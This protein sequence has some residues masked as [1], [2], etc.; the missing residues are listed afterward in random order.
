MSFK[1]SSDF[2]IVGLYFATNFGAPCDPYLIS[3]AVS[4]RR[5]G[6]KCD[7]SIAE[8][9]KQEINFAILVF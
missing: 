1:K 4:C 7:K 3:I 8:R 5:A 6:S 9:I 2:D